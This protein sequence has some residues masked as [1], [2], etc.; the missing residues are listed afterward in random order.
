MSAQEVFFL[1]MM[2][3]M[4]DGDDD[5]VKA[6]SGSSSSD[7]SYAL[8]GLFALIGI[9]PICGGV[10]HYVLASKR[11]SGEKKEQIPQHD[12]EI[13]QQ[14]NTGTAIVLSSV[15]PNNNI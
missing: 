11:D 7:K 10:Y 4:T 3:V 9:L 12:I 13:S 2:T 14:I 5:N 15:T 6:K 8:Y 1:P